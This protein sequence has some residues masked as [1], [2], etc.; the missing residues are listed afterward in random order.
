MTS[1]TAVIFIHGLAADRTVWWPVMDAI[2]ELSPLTAQ[3]ISLPGHG[4]EPSVA[5]P[6]FGGYAAHVADRIDPDVEGILVVGHSLGTL[7][8]AVLAGGMFGFRIRGFMGIAPKLTWSE[9][10]VTASAERAARGRRLFSSIE[11]AARAVRRMSGGTAEAD[12]GGI[13]RLSLTRGLTG[14]YAGIFDPMSSPTRLLGSAANEVIDSALSSVRCPRR[15]LVG[16]EDSG[17]SL[18]ELQRY[19]PQAVEV[20]GVGHNPHVEVPEIV[21]RW[22]HDFASEVL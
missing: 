21:A 18:E 10:E 7:V 8:G 16:S 3:S 5:R 12:S 1:K 4:G 2:D 20:D 11:E 9:G 22:V 15:M 17:V 14:G 19:D 13:D 6:S